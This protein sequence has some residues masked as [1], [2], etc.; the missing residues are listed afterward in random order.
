M[1]E[2]ELLALVR[3]MPECEQSSHFGTVDFRVR[4]KIFCTHPK[5]DQLN[6]KLTREQQQM[7]VETEPAVFRPLPNKWGLKGWTTAVVG[8]LDKTTARSALRMAW[9][10]VASKS[11]RAEHG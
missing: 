5:L 6:L 2:A 10:N 1:R 3:T 9:E 4:N 7:L 8:K 11:L